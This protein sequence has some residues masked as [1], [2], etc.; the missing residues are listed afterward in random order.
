VSIWNGFDDLMLTALVCLYWLNM[1]VRVIDDDGQCA[2]E[3]LARPTCRK[4]I[5]LYHLFIY[6]DIQSFDNLIMLAL[7]FRNLKDV[8]TGKLKY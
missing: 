6:M 4:I 1:G 7:I 8:S 3:G 5:Y 2:R